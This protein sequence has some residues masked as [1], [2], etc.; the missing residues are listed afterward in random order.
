MIHFRGTL[1]FP[2]DQPSGN[3]AADSTP[4]EPIKTGDA[5]TQNERAQS[6]LKRH[7]PLTLTR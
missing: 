4:D 3:G 1:M 2:I 6:V 7:R 5:Q